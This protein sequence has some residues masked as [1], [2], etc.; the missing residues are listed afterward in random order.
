MSPL[1]VEM[2][3]T[4]EFIQVKANRICASV[5]RSF[6]ELVT[7]Q[8]AFVDK[9]LLI[10]DILDDTSHDILIT[11]PH[12]WGKTL[13][14]DMLRSFFHPDIDELGRFDFDKPA[15]SRELFCG[16]EKKID[17][18]F[19]DRRC[20]KPLLICKEDEGKYMDRQGQMPVL[21]VCF[22]DITDEHDQEQHDTFSPEGVLSTIT[23]SIGEMIYDHR[24]L[25]NDLRAII[26]SE[27]SDKDTKKQAA[28]DLNTFLRLRNGF[29]EENQRTT[30]RDLE[31]SILFLTRLLHEH[32][33]RKV[34]VLVDDYDAP[35]N[36]SIGKTFASFVTKVINN[37]YKNGFKNNHNIDK[38]VMMGTLPLAKSKLPA[39]QDFKLFS[40]SNDNKYV[41]RFG[42]TENEVEQLLTD[43]LCEGCDIDKVAN[44]IKLWFDGYSI[45]KYQL[46]NPWSILNC[47]E[48]SEHDP[49]HAFHPY[50]IDSGEKAL[51][52]DTLVKLRHSSDR[53]LGDLMSNNIINYH[54]DLLS[55]LADLNDKDP[56]PKAFLS[57]LLHIG[58]LTRVEH[59][60]YKIPNIEV[61]QHFYKELLPIWMKR[62]LNTCI[63]EY[64]ID[65]LADS[66]EDG[67][68]Y[69]SIIQSKLLNK[70]D[71]SDKTEADFQALLAGLSNYA[72]IVMLPHA[73]H[74]PHCEVSVRQ[75][76]IDCIF[77]PLFTKSDSVI[78]HQ[79]RFSHN[80]PIQSVKR[81]EWHR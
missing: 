33:K 59:D 40:I 32:F 61:K 36:T 28:V 20:L 2:S 69:T 37:I 27:S 78:I 34:M 29:D 73:K 18:S 63:E 56:Q 22:S 49:T 15:S 23:Y 52:E 1:Q 11:R 50:W 81:D 71:S 68:K 58:Y 3:P 41:E 72:N 25:L 55:E 8:C 80:S 53:E 5:R 64:V 16:Y 79:E 44:N 45:G 48:W 62:K 38:C 66:I 39:L 54:I 42:F 51:I 17:C 4:E 6:R 7:D 75:K 21:F 46:Y 67:T 31:M 57:L 26:E 9:S 60:I 30:N 43:N 74:I 76:R 13:N 24:Y 14:L 47:L 35:I 12:R 19:R 77:T 65:D 70:I 10:K